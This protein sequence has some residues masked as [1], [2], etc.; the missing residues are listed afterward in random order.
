[1]PCSGKKTDDHWRGILTAS[2]VSLNLNAHLDVILC[3]EEL[4]K[5]S[6][7]QKV[8][9]GQGTTV[10]VVNPLVIQRYGQM[11]LTRHKDRC[12]GCRFNCLLWS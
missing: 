1:M 3:L 5:T 9:G 6:I 10:S 4:S 12:Q 11:K 7:K 8:G 2:L